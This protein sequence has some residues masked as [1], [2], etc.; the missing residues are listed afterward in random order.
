MAKDDVIEIGRRRR[1]DAEK[2]TVSGSLGKRAFDLSAFGR[3][4]A[5]EQYSGAAG[6]SCYGGNVAV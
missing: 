6:R 5:N 4:V 1:R 2:C 3:Q